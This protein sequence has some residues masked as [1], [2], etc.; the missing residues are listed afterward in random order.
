MKRKSKPRGIT[1]FLA[2]CASVFSASFCVLLMAG[3]YQSAHS[4]LD[5]YNREFQG[6]QACQQTKPAYFKDNKE[7]VSSCIRGLYKARN[8]FWVTL[9]KV[10]LAGLFVLAALGSALCGYLA[11]RLV[12]WFG[13]LAFYRFFRWLALCF[14]RLPERKG[15]LS[16]RMA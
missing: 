16:N 11:A 1:F 8:N 10:Q 6:W 12:V 2:I 9:P 3:E 4:K 15:P 14:R 5:R 13:G 7:A